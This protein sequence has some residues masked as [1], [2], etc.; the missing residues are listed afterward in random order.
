MKRINNRTILLLILAIITAGLILD[1]VPGAECSMQSS[2]FAITAYV[3]SGGGGTMSSQNFRIQSTIGQSTPL[4]DQD[5]P[6][7]ST[8][9]DLYPGFWYAL[10]NYPVDNDL[11][12]FSSAFGSRVGD[13]FYNFY[14]DYNGDGDVDGDDLYYFIS[15]L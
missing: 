9:F 8:T 5:I 6:P 14:Y 11:S 7:Y 15:G 12:A 3:V 10:A 4:M 2:H 1:L 13:T